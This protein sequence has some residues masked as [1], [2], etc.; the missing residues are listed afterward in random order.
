MGL[1]FYNIKKW[2]KMLT[3]KSI[4]HVNQDMG[5]CYV[6]GKI[7]GYFNNLT[8]KVLKD[9]ETLKNET[10]PVTTDEKA[11]K[12]HFPV[13]IIQY[14]LG[15]YD[16]YL[17]DHRK[18]YLDQFWRCVDY[19][20]KHQLEN[21]A[22]DN[23]GFVYPDAPYGSMCQ[24]EACSLLLRAYKES[25]DS[26]YLSQAIRAIDF[27]LLPLCDGGTSE[28]KGDDLF[29]YEFTNKPVVLNGWIF[30]LFGLHE[31]AVVT[32]EQKYEDNLN[33]T[34]QTLKKNL[35]IFDNGYWS[36][37]DMGNKIASPFY[38]NLH[39]AQMQA[40]A[41]TFHSRIFV[42]YYKKFKE[43]QV[44]KLNEIRAFAKKA[45]QKITEK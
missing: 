7:E 12:V 43:Y 5:K 36:M 45:F 1:S 37:Y 30:S 6:P 14:G 34:V 18:I 13:A 38:H 33:K 28:Y 8:D 3:G 35:H 15:A 20:S 39:V 44:N 29:L 22:W 23:F 40:L 32:S 11:G 31:L 25:G 21:G 4:M 19:I 24:G 9:P 10:I 26:E 17:M 42:N 2:T 27:M 16:L 41:E